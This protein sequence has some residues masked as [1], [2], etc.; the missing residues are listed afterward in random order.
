MKSDGVGNTKPSH[1]L[2]AIPYSWWVCLHV[3]FKRS[4]LVHLNPFHG[5][6]RYK[7]WGSLRLNFTSPSRQ[8]CIMLKYK[9]DLVKVISEYSRT[10]V[11]DHFIDYA[12]CVTFMNIINFQYFYILCRSLVGINL[13]SLSTIFKSLFCITCSLLAR[14]D[15]RQP[16][17][18]E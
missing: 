12:Q 6:I 5:F 13:S 15:W 3:E 18:R 8:I 17:L 11:A 4:C 7:G 16:G 1:F 9:V 10:S 2:E 14:A